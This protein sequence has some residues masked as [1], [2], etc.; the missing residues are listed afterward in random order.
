MPNKTRFVIDPDRTYVV[1][2]DNGDEVEVTG[3]DIIQMG[4]QIQKTDKLL[5]TLQDLDEE[6]KGWF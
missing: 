5:K 3:L 4:Y 1:K 6:G 2:L